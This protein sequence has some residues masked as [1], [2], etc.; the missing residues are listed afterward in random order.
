MKSGEIRTFL[1]S[2][3]KIQI[4]NTHYILNIANDITQYRKAVEALNESEQKYRLLFEADDDGI[5]LMTG[6]NFI[7]CN[8]AALKIYG[9]SREDILYK[10][11]AEFSPDY[12]PDGNLSESKAKQM[13]NYAYKGVA[14]SFYWRHYRLDKTEFD[15]EIILKKITISGKPHLLAIVRDVTEKRLAEMQAAKYLNQLA[16]AE[17]TAHMGSC[18]IDLT[19]GNTVWSD[20]FYRICGL[21]P[22]TTNPNTARSRELI[23]PDDREKVAAAVEK[24]LLN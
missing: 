8:P 5:L 2:A 12:Q 7:E 10:N 15:A 21:E 20:E 4:R 11:P 17:K 9:C 14:Q 22:K 24:T 13:M 16:E 3:E 1:Y 19:T 23:H 18:E 6:E